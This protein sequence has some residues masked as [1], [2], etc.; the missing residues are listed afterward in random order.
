MDRVK[1]YHLSLFQ[2]LEPRRMM[3]YEEWSEPER[4]IR[5]PHAIDAFSSLPLN[6]A[7]QTVAV[8]DSGI[9]YN[10]PALGG[11]FGSGFK[12]A[13]GYDFVDNDANPMDTLGHGTQV[14]GVIGADTFI[15]EGTRHRGIAPAAKLLALR[16][17]DNGT[18]SVPDS[19]IEQALKWC[20]ANRET[21]G[22]NVVNISYGTGQFNE[23]AVST[24]YGDELE[25]L[26]GLGVIIVAASGNGGLDSGK[27]IDL[28]AADPHVISVGSVDTQGRI[29]EFT[30]RGVP[31]DLL[32]PGE[33][34]YTTDLNGMY[35][36]VDGTSFASPMVA[37]A[38]ALMH[39]IDTSLSPRDAQSILSVSGVSNVDGDDEIGRSTSLTFPRLDLLSALKLTEAR[40]PADTTA[41]GMVGQ[42]GNGN[43]VA[44]DKFGVTHFVY[45]DS[46]V[47]TMQY[48][49]MSTDGEWSAKEIIDNS[50]PFQGY[51]LSLAVDSFGRPAVAFF[52]GQNG[53]LEYA[54]RG[55]DGWT[56]Q[57]VDV[58]NSTGLYPAMVFDRNDLP[59][60]SY[61]RKTSG[62]LRVARLGDDGNWKITGVDTEDDVGRDTSIA[63]D[64]AGR[65]GVAYA[66]S[67]R[68]SLKYALFD[69]RRGDWGHRTVD[70]APLGGV[71]FTSTAFD[72]T[73]RPIISY[74]DAHSADL[75]VAKLNGRAWETSRVARRGAT[76]LFSQVRFNQYG[77]IDVLY[78]D[79][80]RNSVYLASGEFGNWTYTRLK[81]DG[82]RYIAAATNPAD[83][84]FRYTYYD[85]A[86]G[87]LFFSE[88]TST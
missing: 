27:G 29:S 58:K 80:R 75:K 74:Y 72:A 6:G 35:S 14:A 59:V 17:D 78:Y 62:D 36:A 37:G 49:T 56:T 42:F 85:T 32:A 79:K 86:T 73:N 66:D 11:G 67:T 55:D 69:S 77:M 52:D 4:M 26:D 10:H 15:A 82:G 19:R 84:T 20:L 50:L 23:D 63:I 8:I 64:D 40:R 25:Q 60:I 83:D 30:E 48:S 41:Q 88:V 46:A 1:L 51:Y 22:I 81:T 65:I 31:L 45:Y 24:V 34:V 70:A 61:Y 9:D 71:S 18:T 7:G 21:F 53:D 39:S 43:S 44:I 87:K 16:V 33:A 47:G 3:A 5:L 2:S 76:G 12:V 57:T 38:V 54:T 13:G 68:G 28:P